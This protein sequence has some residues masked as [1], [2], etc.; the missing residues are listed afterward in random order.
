MFDDEESQNLIEVEDELDAVDEADEE[1]QG[2]T[3][4]K[5]CEDER[6]LKSSFG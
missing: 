3:L 1:M 6:F 2:K 5:V 4:G